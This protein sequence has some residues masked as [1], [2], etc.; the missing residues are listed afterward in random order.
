[1]QNHNPDTVRSGAMRPVPRH[2][3]DEVNLFENSEDV[4]MVEDTLSA[5]SAYKTATDQLMVESYAEL[6][7][8]DFDVRKAS[9]PVQAFWL[10]TI[11]PTRS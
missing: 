8:Q 4:D 6:A 1:M 3:I 10:R 9:A 7:G 5:I 2:F 11:P